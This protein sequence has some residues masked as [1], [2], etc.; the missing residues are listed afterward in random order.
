MGTKLARVLRKV[1]RSSLFELMQPQVE[2]SFFDGGA[3]GPEQILE[4]S[5]ESPLLLKGTSSKSP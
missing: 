4:E 1:D 5:K 3:E 2:E